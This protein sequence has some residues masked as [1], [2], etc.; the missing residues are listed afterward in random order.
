MHTLVVL[1]SQT[2][3]MQSTV[4]GPTANGGVVPPAVVPPVASVQHNIPLLHLAGVCS[5]TNCT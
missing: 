4:N 1:Q 3:Q 2:L 5:L